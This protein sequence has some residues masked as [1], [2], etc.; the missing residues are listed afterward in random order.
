MAVSLVAKEPCRIERG[1]CTAACRNL[2]QTVEEYYHKKAGRI[3][4]AF[5]PISDMRQLHQRFLG[6]DE[7]TDVLSFPEGSQSKKPAGDIA[8]CPEVVS[9][10]E[11]EDGVDQGYYLLEAILHGMLHLFGLEHDYSDESLAEVYALQRELLERA[12]VHW[13]ND[14]VYT[15]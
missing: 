11:Q 3:S 6:S 5:L 12:A 1:P 9:S 14:Y 4:I 15:R 8:V 7:S 13:S 10:R 2:L